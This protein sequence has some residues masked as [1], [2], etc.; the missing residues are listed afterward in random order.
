MTYI[1]PR[2]VIGTRDSDLAMVQA[3]HV[4]DLLK[5]AFPQVTVD[6]APMKAAGDLH[7]GPLSQIG[8]KAVWVRELDRALATARVDVTVSCA[9][10]LP[11]PHERGTD[12]TIGAVLPREDARDAL[13]LP[14]GRPPTTLDDLPP[15]SVIGTSAPRRIAQLRASYP[16]LT[17]QPVRG[18]LLPRLARLDAGEGDKPLDALVVSYA[19]LCRVSKADRATQLIPTSVLAPATGAG[20]LVVEHRSGDSVAAHLLT[21]LND[22]ATARLLAVE[23]GILAQLKGNCQTACSVNAHYV[24]KPDRIRVDAAVFHP[25]G[26]DAI[27]VAATGPADD[28]GGLVENI[29]QLLHGQEVERLLPR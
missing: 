19:G 24:D 26:D 16:R 1:P 9:K 23:R 15:V 28:L 27:Q 20:T 13:V 4:A 11:G 10:D 17:I 21:A 29:T 14:A 12:T 22:P 7:Q 5:R 25:S 2:L 6:L 8:G 3:A 18:N